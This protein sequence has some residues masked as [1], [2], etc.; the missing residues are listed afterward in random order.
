MTR[1]PRVTVVIPTF[2]R[3]ALLVEAVDSVLRQSYRDLEIV[4]C[5]DGSTDDTAAR[6]RVFGT[7]ARYMALP[8]TG[9]PGVP[10]NCG[11]E[12]AHG[13]LVAFLDDDD[14]WEPEKL[15]RQIELMETEGISLAYTDRR[16][17]FSE[18]SASEL[19]VTPSPASPDR[20]LDLVLEGHFPSVCTML[21]RRALLKQ[22]NGF[23]ETLATAEDLDLWLRL[24]PI[25]HAG[26]VPQPLVVVRRTAGSLSDRNGPLTY[27]NAI[28]VLERSLVTDDL[29]PNQRRL[30]RATLARMASRL[31][32][33]LADRGE[34]RAATRAALRAL[35]HA[36]ASRA[37]WS[38]LAKALRVNLS[39]KP[40]H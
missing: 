39:A 22:I 10:R 40:A 15:A 14:L 20:L 12:A 25:A 37:A 16:I 34:A 36:P 31:A 7:H 17:Q 35:R 4:I 38:A 2:N 30:G 23:D 33:V 24:A 29:L 1:G 19:A 27:Q 28:G 13:E 21:V 11:I 18:G 9:R 5:D 8:H 6:V 26:R 3:A 32:L